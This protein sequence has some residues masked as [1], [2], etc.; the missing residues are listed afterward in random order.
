[1]GQLGH[2]QMSGSTVIGEIRRPS[3]VIESKSTRLER[4]QLGH[5]REK[6]MTVSLK[7]GSLLDAG[8]EKLGHCVRENQ[9]RVSFDLAVYKSKARSLPVSK[10]RF[11]SVNSLHSSR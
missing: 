7:R 11:D 1:M 3:S 8:F 2:S 4:R 9:T 6:C 5:R 10:H